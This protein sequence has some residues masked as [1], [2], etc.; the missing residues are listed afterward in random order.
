M[1]VSVSDT[2]DS[3]AMLYVCDSKEN[4]IEIIGI[5]ESFKISESGIYTVVGVN[6]AGE[7]QALNI[8]VSRNAPTLSIRENEEE[9]RLE[10]QITESKDEQSHIKTLE[11]YKSTDNGQTW[12]LITVDDYGLTVSTDELFYTFR[13]SGMYKVVIT[14]EFYTGIEAITAQYTYLQKAPTG[15]LTGVEN[16]GYTNGAVTFKWKDEATVT[17]TK[18]GEVIEYRSGAE[19][20]QDGSYTITIENIDGYKTTYFFVIDREAPEVSFNGTQKGKSVSGEC[21]T[22][23]Y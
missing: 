22:D 10:I 9:K 16:N 5:G 17:I 3:M 21:C 6:H 15:T 8:I 7:T 19:L 2:Y 11:I 23:L 13:M 14:D 12:E 4:V 18:D 1:S 20:R